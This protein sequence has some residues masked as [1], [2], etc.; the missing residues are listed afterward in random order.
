MVILLNLVKTM[1]SRG[2]DV[3]GAACL[4]SARAHSPSARHCQ[5]LADGRKETQELKA[6]LRSNND[7]PTSN[8]VTQQLINKSWASNSNI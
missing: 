4:L 5:E 2:R 1:G 7:R 8:D 3:E 6:F